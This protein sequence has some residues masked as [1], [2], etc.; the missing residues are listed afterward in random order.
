MAAMMVR[1][2]PIRS[3]IRPPMSTPAVPS[4]LKTMS[5]K[6][7]GAVSHCRS[8]TSRSITKAVAGEENAATRKA[9]AA[10]G[11]KWRPSPALR[12]VRNVTLRSYWTKARLS[13]KNLAS[14]GMASRPSPVSANS[15]RYAVSELSAIGRSVNPIPDPAAPASA[16]SPIPRARICGDSSSARITMASPATAITAMRAT[17]WAMVKLTGSEATA[18]AILASGMRVNATM[19]G[20]RRPRRSA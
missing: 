6:R 5:K 11:Q 19:N 12:A 14:S 10:M 7:A 9:I 20:S 2:R 4:P 3:A 15:V 1:L 18:V 17:D 8:S 16:Y 13:F